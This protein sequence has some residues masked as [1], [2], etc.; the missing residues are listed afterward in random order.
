MSYDRYIFLT[1]CLHFSDNDKQPLP[2]AKS[3]QP[4]AASNQPVTD[5]KQL[6][7]DNRKESVGEKN[8]NEENDDNC[9]ERVEAGSG[10]ARSR[11]Q[12]CRRKSK[13]Q[14]SNPPATSDTTPNS[15]IMAKAPTGKITQVVLNLLEDLE[16]KGHCVTVDNFYKS[17]VGTIPQMSRFRLSG[18]NTLRLT[19][20]SALLLNIQGNCA[21]KGRLYARNQRWI[22]IASREPKLAKTNEPIELD[23]AIT[24]NQG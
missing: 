7:A 3:K 17:S 6:P 9:D 21:S 16:H 10:R 24:E 18:H 1:K 4:L 14:I 13:K 12:K 19:L 22:V 11:G 2:K 15:N 5:C 8:N 20:G 23:E